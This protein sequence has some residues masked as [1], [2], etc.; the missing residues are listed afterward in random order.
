M[1]FDQ[2]QAPDGVKLLSKGEFLCYSD[3]SG[4][5]TNVKVRS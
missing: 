3:L 4:R 5:M 1:L 2:S